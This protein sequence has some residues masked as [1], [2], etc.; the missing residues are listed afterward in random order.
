LASAKRIVERHGGE[1]S[2]RSEKD[3]GACFI[4][5]LQK[6]NEEQQIVS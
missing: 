1:I 6:Y 3:H 5:S 4:F 2:V